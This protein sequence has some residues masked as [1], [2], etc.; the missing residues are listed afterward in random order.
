M[1]LEQALWVAN[2]LPEIDK[3]RLIQQLMMNMELTTLTKLQQPK[4]SSF[5]ILANLGT[6][7]SE[8]EIDQVRREMSAKSQQQRCI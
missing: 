3:L 8:A 5:G 6:A 7:P 2:Q 1:T 4:I